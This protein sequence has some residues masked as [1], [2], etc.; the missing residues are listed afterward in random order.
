MAGLSQCERRARESLNVCYQLQETN[1]CFKRVAPPLQL[2]L[3]FAIE[4]QLMPGL[5]A[6]P[7]FEMDENFKERLIRNVKKEVKQ[8]MEEA[9]TRKFVHEESS[10]ITSLCAAVEACLSQGLRRRALGLFKTSSTTALLHKVAKSFPPAHQISRM[11]QELENVEPSN[12]KSSSSGDSTSKPL[13]PPLLKKNSAG[14]LSQSHHH[15]PKYLWIRLALLEKQLAGIIAYLVENSSRYYEKDSLVADPDCGSILSS[16]LVGPCAL[17]YSKTKTQDHFWTDPPADEL[18]QRHRISSGATSCQPTPPLNFGRSLHTGGSSEDSLGQMPRSAKDY[19]ESLHQNSK[20]TLLYGKNNVNVHPPQSDPMPGYL[21]LHQSAQGLVIKW[22]PN[23][24]MNGFAINCSS[25]TGGVGGGSD[26]KEGKEG[27]E[28]K[29]QYWQYALNLRV[30]DIV[31]VHCHQQGGG[32]GGG[33]VV[34][35]GQDGV[36]RPPI[37]FP[38]GQGHMLSFLSCLENGLLPMGQLDPPLWSQRGKGKA[39]PRGRR[40][41]VPLP[42]QNQEAID[43]VFRIINKARQEDLL[44][45]QELMDPGYRRGIAQNWRILSSASASASSSDS[46]HTSES[47]NPPDSPAVPPPELN[48]NGHPIRL[49]CQTMKRQIISRAFYGWLAYCRHL[50]TVRTHLSGLVN[51]KIVE[52]S[53]EDREGLTIERWRVLSQNGCVSDNQQVLRLAY[54]GGVAA[55]LR[56]EV[57]PY[58]LGHYLWGSSSNERQDLD[59]GTRQS[60]ETTMSQWLA[61]EAVAR[62]RDRPGSESSEGHSSEAD[63]ETESDLGDS[64]EDGS[65]PNSPVSS[66]GGIYARDFLDL[67]ALNLHRI[68]KDVQ[69]C[70][71][72][73]WYFAP[74]DNLEKLRNIMCTYVWERLDVGYMQGMCD[75]VAPLLVVF[76]DE[77]KTYACFC[78][79][80]ERMSANF[81]HG[82]AMDAHFANMRSLIQILDAELFELMHQHGDYTHFYFCYRWFL[83]DFKRELI[84]EDVFMVWEVIWAARYVASNHFVLFLALALVQTYRDIILTNSMDFT[85]IIKFFNEMAERHDARAVLALSR[86]LV[87]QLQTLIENK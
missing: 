56:G 63:Q 76:D 40:R 59:E 26:G 79:L 65:E 74:P 70:D 54:Y 15:P 51:G 28:D 36:Q 49:V 77:A 18:V 58:L 64:I 45:T 62:Q 2:H 71:R 55:E 86:E 66:Q 32:E 9:V 37:C 6:T 34:L 53:T 29:S 22:T 5:D 75:L 35:V 47:L 41:P 12:R 23:Q 72:N 83:L 7:S 82:S 11:V 87:L 39:F 20:A 48:S 4:L 27:K 42:D 57:W 73:Y 52:G 61:A 24:L 8:I 19:V 81:P 80:M 13:P 67:F 3:E 38:T 69:R 16:L 33:T 14:V 17:D 21:S 46:P 10:S 84:Y 30:E 31:Y 68:D 43:Y 50:S 85:D 1:L 60:Y 78:N 25:E 44:L